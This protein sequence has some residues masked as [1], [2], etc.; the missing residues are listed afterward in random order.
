MVKDLMNKEDGK[1]EPS[2]ET[3]DDNIERFKRK[4]KKNYN[5]I[6]KAGSLF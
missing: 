6:T 3:F 5:F 2:K 1:F 4:G